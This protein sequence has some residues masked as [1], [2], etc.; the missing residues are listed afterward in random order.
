M[1][2][3]TECKKIANPGNSKQ[4]TRRTEC[5]KIAARKTNEAFKTG[6]SECAHTCRWLRVLPVVLVVVLPP[7]LP[8][9]PLPAPNSRYSEPSGDGPVVRRLRPGLRPAAAARPS[10]AWLKVQDKPSRA[11]RGKILRNS[12]RRGGSQRELHQTGRR[13]QNPNHHGAWKPDLRA[14]RAASLKNVVA[15]PGGRVLPSWRSIP[16]IS[17]MNR[18]QKLWSR[19][20]QSGH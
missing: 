4:M 9:V 13:A 12:R 2:R 11:K 7:V 18:V 8:V 15:A 5:K 19:R 10:R 3:R 17:R 16:L 6:A 20:H 1:T 14:K